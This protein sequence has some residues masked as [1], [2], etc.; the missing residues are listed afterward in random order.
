MNFI[1][2]TRLLHWLAPRLKGLASKRATW[3]LSPYPAGKSFGF[4][5]VHDADSAYSQRLAPIMESLDA[6][7]FKITVTVF[8][9]WAT[10]A[11]DPRRMWTEWRTIDPFAAP[12]A[13]PL[14]D[15]DERRFYLDLRDRGHEIAVHTPSETSSLRRDVARA[16]AFFEDVFGAPARMY[17]EHSPGNNLDAQCR[18][19]SDT[20]SEYFNTDLL[21]GSGCW[22]W[23]CDN[24]TDFP[25]RRGRQLDVLSDSSGPFSPRANEKYGI[26]RGFIRSRVLPSDGDGFLAS[27]TEGAVDA[28]VREGGTAIVYAHLAIGWLD[29][30]TRR[31][32]TD[33]EQCL[34]KIAER[35]P[36]SVPAS[37]MLDRFAAFRNVQLNVSDNAIEVSNFGD[38]ALTEVAIRSPEGFSLLDADGRLLTRLSRNLLLLGDVAPRSSVRLYLVRH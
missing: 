10:W 37:D 16:F 2:G 27:L 14:E 12:V 15:P 36:W 7:G 3:L 25:R 21:N 29:P 18:F 28:L 33:I 22:I 9:F 24:E 38:L 20:Q 26:Q 31:L 19:G 23:V 1:A 4:T 13:V 17:V 35:N 6:L 11:A 8:P 5:I 34:R 30:Q 32:R